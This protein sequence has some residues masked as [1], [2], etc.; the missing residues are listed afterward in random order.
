METF[1]SEAGSLQKVAIAFD[2]VALELRARRELHAFSASPYD[3]HLL[4]H[5]GGGAD[6]TV[7][8]LAWVY[9][10][11]LLRLFLALVYDLLAAADDGIQW[12]HPLV[13]ERIRQ[14]DLVRL[15]DAHD[16]SLDVLGDLVD[17]KHG[18]SGPIN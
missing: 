15:F 10:I 14:L 12:R 11:A 18:E 7:V 4:L 3:H 17:L 9:N 1:V 2:L 13:R 6:K 5:G 8:V 16:E